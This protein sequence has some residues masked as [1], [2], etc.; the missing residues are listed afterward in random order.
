MVFIIIDMA[1]MG[2]MFYE[3]FRFSICH[4]IFWQ[5]ILHANAQLEKSSD[6]NGENLNT[7]MFNSYKQDMDFKI[8]SRE[9]PIVSEFKSN[10]EYSQVICVYLKQKKRQAKRL[11]IYGSLLLASITLNYFID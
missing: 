8:L 6:I 3:K 4:N 11:V 7:K 2:L 5:R 10:S 9:P 1:L